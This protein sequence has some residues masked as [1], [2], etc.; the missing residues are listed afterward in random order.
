MKKNRNHLEVFRISFSTVI[1][2]LCVAVYLLCTAGIALSVIRIVKYGV[3]DFSD[4]L[5]YPFLIGVCA[6]CILL[7]TGVL[8]KSQYVI[9]NDSL[10]TQFGFVKSK[11]AIKD[12]TSLLYDPQ[13]KKMTVYF[14][15]PFMT[16]SVS[17]EWQDRFVK[18]L[19]QINPDIEYSF[20]LSTTDEKKKK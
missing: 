11:Y 7:I 8:I 1:Y 6:F 12:I 14:G 16:L 18:A 2:L 5:R 10:V 3:E 4:I 17:S 20:T 19:L 13:L 15:E 9:E